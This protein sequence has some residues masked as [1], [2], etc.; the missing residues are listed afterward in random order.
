MPAM[1]T[2]DRF[3][4]KSVLGRGAQG[5]VYLATDKRLERQVALKTLNAGADPAAAAQ[6][7]TEARM[8]SGLQHPNI[9]TL[10]DA[11]QE[12]DGTYLVYEY[13][14]GSTL[15]NMIRERGHLP[16][17]QAVK[18]TIDVLRALVFAHQ[19]HTL[20]CD[21]K[22]SNVLVAADGTA[23]VMDFGI[24]QRTDRRSAG[25]TTA[26][27]ISA[28][29]SGFSGTPCYLAPEIAAG[30]ASSVASD[31]FSV[32]IM[33]YEMLCGKP[34]ITGRTIFETI[35]RM[36]QETFDAVAS[37]NQ[38][39][40]P[41]L[42]QIVMH[43]IAKLPAD[44]FASATA[45]IGALEDYLVPVAE[46]AAAGEGSS[47]TLAFLIQRMRFKSDFPV[48]SGAVSAIN[49]IVASDREPTSKL[50]NII[51]KDV[52]LTNKIL[53]IINAAHYNRFGGAISTVSRAVSLLG[54]DAVR[55]I[56]LSLV[57]FEHLQNQQQAA[58]LQDIIGGCFFSSVFAVELAKSVGRADA[59]EMAICAMFH[60]LGKLVA[61][62][63]LHEEAKQIASVAATRN[64]SDDRAAR[65]VIGV[66]YSELGAG[67]AR[68]WNLPGEII[69]SMG[70]CDDAQVSTSVYDHQPAR[71]FASCATEMANLA[72]HGDADS[73]KANLTRI[74]GKYAKSMKI[75]P[76]TMAHVVERASERFKTDTA[77]I[78]LR[79]RTKQLTC[80]AS[81]IAATMRGEEAPA[82]ADITNAGQVVGANG[83]V[84]GVS[85]G[86]DAVTGEIATSAL[87]SADDRRA[88]LLA[89]IQDITDTLAG[90]YDLN[91]ALRI[92]LETIYRGA[93]FDRVML[94]SRAPNG[95]SMICRHAFGR[96]GE[97]LVS[98]GFSLSLEPA[99]TVFY[100]ALSRGADV[101]IQDVNSAKVAPLMPSW[102]AKKLGARGMLLLPLM[103]KARAIGLIYADCAQAVVS[104]DEADLRLLRTLRSQA[105]MAI[106][107]KDF[108]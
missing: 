53:R 99:R 43:A 87:P 100:G 107:Q 32:G 2:F 81:Y 89:G 92:I 6:Q 68:H 88:Q 41:K 95:R 22:P 51:L 40:D 69:D 36:A 71:V 26:A 46:P 82:I 7:L 52:S 24:A 28:P 78:G 65:E 47:A 105:V 16:A 67:V 102:Y 25:A 50:T 56:A 80:E 98:E 34:P 57:L 93:R 5:T 61:T 45:F 77:A 54:F 73:R 33:L 66:T 84:G 35:H 97:R 70:T 108:G 21:L 13:I 64:L 49:R 74:M 9:V 17:Q 58:D 18:L 86:S 37:R 75:T 60:T 83:N 79:C 55:N 19:R 96:D 101:A 91:Q 30:A 39:V 14:D 106:R 59:E 31:L 104:F 4:L 76:E 12:R 11:Q 94:F 62:F 1:P 3:T 42:N 8:V 27:T 29:P 72:V 90:E 63:Y 10:F 38:D 103:V 15:S 23:R 48:L 44:R 20:H 85:G